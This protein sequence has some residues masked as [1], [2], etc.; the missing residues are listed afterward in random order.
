MKLENWCNSW[1]WRC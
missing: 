1:W